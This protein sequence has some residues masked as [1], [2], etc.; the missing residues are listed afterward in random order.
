MSSRPA[1]LPLCHSG[2]NADQ[3]ER[4][5]LEFV[6]DPRTEEHLEMQFDFILVF[7][8][9]CGNCFINSLL[10]YNCWTMLSESAVQHEPAVSI[11]IAHPS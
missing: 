6:L 2:Q 9:F 7:I 5:H 4:L 1:Q 3:G 11:H 8:I 10:E